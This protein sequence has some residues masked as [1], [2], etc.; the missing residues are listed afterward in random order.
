AKGGDGRKFAGTAADVELGSDPI[1]ER[2]EELSLHSIG[3]GIAPGDGVAA[4]RRRN[5][6]R[7]VLI[8]GYCRVDDDLRTDFRGIGVEKLGMDGKAAGVRQYMAVILPGH[9]EI[10]V[11]QDRNLR[12]SRQGHPRVVGDQRGRAREDAV[13]GDALHEDLM[14]VRVLV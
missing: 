7:E 2:V 8:G 1:S 6:S 10:A 5:D 14:C 13:T 9:Y 4:I 12:P 11:G 3:G